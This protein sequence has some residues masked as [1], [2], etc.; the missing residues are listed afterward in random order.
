MHTCVLRAG[1]AQFVWWQ[2][3]TKLR[4][5]GFVTCR[6]K[7]FISSSMCLCRFWGPPGLLL[8]G[9]SGLFPWA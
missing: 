6:G 2:V 9:F 3:G 5:R 4:N 1:I 7:L 8:S